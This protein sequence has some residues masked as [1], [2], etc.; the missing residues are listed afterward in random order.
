MSRTSICRVVE[1]TAIVLVISGFG[2]LT[3]EKRRSRGFSQQVSCNGRMRQLYIP[4]SEY[5]EKHGHFPF[6]QS[7][8]GSTPRAYEHAHVLTR[9]RYGKTIDSSF[10]VCPASRKSAAEFDADGS[11]TLSPE[12]MGFAWINHP[13]SPKK[14]GIVMA[15]TNHQ[16]QGFV[17]VLTSDGS[18]N[19]IP[20]EELDPKR[21]YVP[22]GLVD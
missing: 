1:V 22:E 14:K 6:L 3:Y 17:L 8:N 13:S 16:D 19:E 20:L 18:V 12:T 21:D 10:F 9:S 11:F 2:W 5:A 15:C 4:M 7:K